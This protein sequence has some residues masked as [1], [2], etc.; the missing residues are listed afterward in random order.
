MEDVCIDL[1]VLEPGSCRCAIIGVLWCL[2]RLSLFSTRLNMFL[3]SKSPQAKHAK[4][5]PAMAHLRWHTSNL[6]IEV[7]WAMQKNTTINHKII[8]LE[9]DILKMHVYT[10]VNIYIYIYTHKHIYIYIYIYI[11]TYVT[12]Y[13]L[14]YSI[15]KHMT[16]YY[17]MVYY[18]IVCVMLH[19]IMIKILQR[20]RVG[21]A[22]RGGPS[23]KPNHAINQ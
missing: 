5:D 20:S 23:A 3:T 14:C 18:R 4:T 13:I 10:Y 19:Y 1:H 6:L 17:I 16:L 9:K 11:H 22:D 7:E 8:K 12:C 15:V 2:R 21:C